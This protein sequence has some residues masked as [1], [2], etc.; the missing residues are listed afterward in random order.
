MLAVGTTLFL[1]SY[2]IPKTLFLFLFYAQAF[3][4]A[5]ILSAFV[6][7]QFFGGSSLSVLCARTMLHIG[8]IILC[9]VLREKFKFLIH[10]VIGSWWPLNMVEVLCFSYTS[11]F[12]LR[13]FDKPY[14]MSELISFLLFL[15]IIIG[16]YVVFFYTIHYMYC[17]SK[18]QRAELQSEFLLEQ[19]KAM[20]ALV[21]ETRRVRHDTRHHNIQI[22]EYA[23]NGEIDALLHYMGEYEKEA[24]SYQTV[25]LCENVSANNILSAYARKARQNGI[26]VHFDTVMEQGIGMRDIDIVTILANLMENAIYGCLYAQKPNPLIDVYIGHKAGKLVICVRNTACEGVILGNGLPLSK[27]RGGVGISSILHST[28]RYGGEYDFQSSKGMF[29]CQLLLKIP[30]QNMM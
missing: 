5:M 10:G 14:G 15:L 2:D 26:D 24:K 29:S 1:S 3:I 13:V 8:I 17:A 4:I 16:V 28:A 22:L 27:D 20:E 21:E 23:K 12:V 9:C 19:M 18:Q 7:Q 11:I 25:R 6:S 30:K